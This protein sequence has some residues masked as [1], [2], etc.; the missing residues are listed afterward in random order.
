MSC[1]LQRF[2]L[3]LLLAVPALVQAAASV[4]V[5]T[6]QSVAVLGG[7][8]REFAVR[9]YDAMGQ[10]AVGENVQFVN[11]ACGV[12]ANG[13]SV[14]SVKTDATGLAGTS[15]TARNQGI[16]CYVIATASVAV[17]FEVVTFTLPQMRLSV[18]TQ[19]ASPHPGAEFDLKVVPN[20]GVYRLKELDISA[21][22]IAGSGSAGVS[23]AVK[24]SGQDG[25]AMFRISPAGFYGDYEVEL[26]YRDLV[27]RVPIKAS[28]TPWQDMWWGGSAENGW[29]MSIV[30]HADTLFSVL[31]AYDAAGKPTWYVMP[32]GTWDA[33]KRVY[34]GPV[35]F[36]HGTPF[37]DYRAADFSAGDPVGHATLRFVDGG[38]A[39]LEF[40][41]GATTVRKRIT[42]QVFG[43]PENATLTGLGDMWWGG[44]AQ[45]GWG[46][47]VLQQYRALFSVWFTYDAAGMPTWFVLPT[48]FWRDA[49]TYEG[50]I[51][52]AAGSQWLGK[53]YDASAFRTTDVGFY[54]LHFANGAL[55]FDYTIEGRSG[56][57]PV[58][59][60][61]F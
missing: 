57:M 39:E 45:N 53:A 18:S 9:F 27:Q 49:Q 34:S 54:R 21:R 29:G 59:R 55:T 32:G 24:S 50:R 60:Q 6:P 41:V 61:P 5:V 37:T 28:A 51:Y 52:R 26:R 25:E 11:D 22:V 56:T 44:P 1:V 20:T 38:N 43:L 10:P 47:A 4:A 15:F 13:S 33:D 8:T 48:G 19:P 31:Y 14:M 36:P 30:Q 46:L 23:P 3:A 12:F 7:T 40:I 17:R 58:V 2:F 35:Y 42:R 16:V